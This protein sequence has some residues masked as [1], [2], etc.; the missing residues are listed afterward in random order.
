MEIV[1]SEK[2]CTKFKPNFFDHVAAGQR[3]LVSLPNGKLLAETLIDAYVKGIVSIP[4][5]PTATDQQIAFYLD[6]GEADYHVQRDH[7]LTRIK[8]HDHHA[9]DIRFIMYTSGTTGNPKG[10]VLERSA[11]ENNATILSQIHNFRDGHA[12]CLPLFHCNALMMSLIGSYIAGGKLF[13]Q[14]RFDAYS[15]FKNIKRHG[16]RTASIVPAL[17]EELVICSPDWPDC[18][19]YLITAAAPLSQDLA[20]RFYDKYGS[21][22]RQ[23]YGLTE[24][25]NFSFLMPSLD[26]N[27]FIQHYVKSH[28]PVGEI[29][30][31]QQFKLLDTGEV[32]LKG[33]STMAGYLKNNTA[34]QQAF[35]NDGWLRTGDL[36]YM[37]D[38]FLVLRGRIKETINRGGET[39]YPVDIEKH[40]EKSGIQR[41]FAAVPI[42]NKRLGEDIGLCFEKGGVSTLKALNTLAPFTPSSV[43]CAPIVQT[44]T[45]KPKRREMGSKLFSVTES[46]IEYSSL[47]SMAACYAEDILK[48]TCTRSLPKAG[49]ATYIINEAESLV[50]KKIP[51]YPVPIDHSLVESVPAM[52]LQQLIVENI[53][54]IIDGTVRGEELVRK[55][56]GLWERLMCEWPMNSYAEMAANFLLDQGLLKGRTLELGAGV[57]NTSRLISAGVNESFIRTDI[58]P[59]ILARLS[60]PGKNEYY[61][62]NAPGRWNNLDTIFAVNA[63]HCAVDK[64]KTIAH[65]YEMLSFDGTLL[66]AE[67]S[68]RTDKKGTPWALNGLFGIFD[69]WWNISGFLRRDQWIDIFVETGFRQWGYSQL[70]SG[71]HDL[72]GLLWAVK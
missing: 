5:G 61:D 50:E 17:L 41:P 33:T 34:T 44:S 10:I 13:I 67:G 24:A 51:L 63:L 43:W 1:S 55:K 56:K 52:Q 38:G 65:L 9:G 42:Y 6:H 45:G 22:L 19:E 14:N 35:T 26:D 70:R 62:F 30:S 12:T 23:G 57:G 11:V 68:P 66:L 46:S 69:G 71:E 32:V 40:W 49:P 48:H 27:S 4:V 39:L 36:G 8:Q 72:G 53:E 21:R 58:N 47:L 31:G 60:H 20:R 18:L 64:H 16:I 29:L 59:E 7:T 2:N 25:V 3:L 37:R 54:G 28:P 15:Y